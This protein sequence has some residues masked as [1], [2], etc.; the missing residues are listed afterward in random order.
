MANSHCFEGTLME[1]QK[2]EQK[3][4][5]KLYLSIRVYLG[6]MTYVEVDLHH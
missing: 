6:H 4:K 2:I 1:L 5:T 3:A